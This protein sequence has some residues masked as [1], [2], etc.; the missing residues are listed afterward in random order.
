MLILAGVGPGDAG[1]PDEART[2]FERLLTLRNDVGL[3]SEEYDPVAHRQLGNTPQAFTHLTLVHAALALG[4]SRVAP[5]KNRKPGSPDARRG[6]LPRPR[7]RV[8]YTVVLA[9]PAEL[10]REPHTAP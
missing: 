6:A 5:A 4:A 1:T 10:G 8:S 3:L 9:R 2:L 7:T